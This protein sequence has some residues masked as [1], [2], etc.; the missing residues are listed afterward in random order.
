[1]KLKARV[2]P[3]TGQRDDLIIALRED[4]N[5]VEVT[6]SG[7]LFVTLL[8][9]MTREGMFYVPDQIR[10]MEYE[11]L[12]NVTEGM[13]SQGISSVICGATTAKPLKPYRIDLKSSLVRFNVPKSLALVEID[14]ERSTIVTKY[15]MRQDGDFIG[16]DIS[17][18]YVG[19]LSKAGLYTPPAKAALMKL[20]GRE[21]GPCYYYPE[22]LP[23]FDS[24]R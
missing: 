13:P 8:K 20:E 18:I 7:I 24:F 11:I 2:V 19:P 23:F 21:P 3:P 4:G 16:V 1:M 6:K 22:A 5:P 12:F 17:D 14:S 15:E 10:G 9:A